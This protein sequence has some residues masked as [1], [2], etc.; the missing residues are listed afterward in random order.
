MTVQRGWRERIEDWR[1]PVPD[2]EID[3]ATTALV[4][5]DMQH[6]CAHARW[7]L[8]RLFRTVDPERADYYFSRVER[9]V[10]PNT[11][12]LLE[13]FRSRGLRVMFLALGPILED[14]SDLSPNFRRRYQQE[15][16][17]L[18]FRVTFPRGTP[19]YAILPEIAPRDD[20]LVINKTANSAFNSSD[21]DRLLRHLGIHSLIVTGVGTDVCVETT[22]RDAIDRGYNCIIVEDACATLDEESHEASL[23]AFAKW[24]GKVANTDEVLALLDRESAGE[25]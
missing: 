15:E 20:E 8:G 9:V 13:F 7:G 24:F 17:A 1:L 5:V 22:A 19:G 12:R 10:V 25:P 18:G 11:Q 3:P 4:I 23:L 2:F 6:T 21:I 14:G 16:E